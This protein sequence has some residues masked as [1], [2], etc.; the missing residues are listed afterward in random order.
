MSL[1]LHYYLVVFFFLLSLPCSHITFRPLVGIRDVLFLEK[2]GVN[3]WELGACR[4]NEV[5]TSGEVNGQISRAGKVFTN[6]ELLDNF[7]QRCAEIT[8]WKCP[9]GVRS[10]PP[11]VSSV[12]EA[13]RVVLTVPG[14]WL[15]SVVCLASLL[16][17]CLAL[18]IN[19][20]IGKRIVLQILNVSVPWEP[21]KFWLLKKNMN[22]FKIWVTFLHCYYPY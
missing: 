20:L 2:A 10:E 11:A 14:P 1:L 17:L 7:A 5:R 6:V 12:A 18:A 19:V 8:W 4:I 13:V 3:W 22:K 16:P 9:M 15:Y 21:Y